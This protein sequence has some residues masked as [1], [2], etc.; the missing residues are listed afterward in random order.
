MTARGLYLSLLLLLLLPC[1]AFAQGGGPGEVK[2]IVVNSDT[3]EALPFAN[4][5]VEGTKFG[6]MTAEDG[7]FSFYVPAGTYTLITSYMGFDK[8]EHVDVVIEPESNKTVNFELKPSVALEMETFFVDG[9]GPVVDVKSSTVK[10]NKDSDDLNAFAVDNVQEAMALEAGITMKGGQLFVRGG[11]AGEVSMMIDGVPVND[12]L[13]GSVQVANVAVANSEAIIGG[14]DAEYGN[15]QSAVFNIVTREGGSQ[16]EGSLRYTTDDY[17]RQ[18]KTYTNFDR[19]AVGIGGPLFHDDFRWFLSAEGNFSDG[20]DL[21]LDRREEWTTLNGL[22]RWTDRARNTMQVTNKLT[23]KYSKNLKFNLEANLNWSTT[24]GYVHN[25]NQ[26]GYVNRLHMFERLE[27]SGEA[28]AEGGM[29]NFYVVRGTMPVKHGPWYTDYYMTNKRLQEQGLPNNFTK[30]LIKYKPSGSSQAVYEIA[31]AMLVN[32][33]YSGTEFYVLTDELFDGYMDTLSRWS[34]VR[35]DSS[36]IYYNSAEHTPTTDSYSNSVKFMAIHNIS[37]NVFYRLALTRLFF[38]NLRTVNGQEPWEYDTAGTPAT[39]HNG[40]TQRSISPSIYYTDPD[41]PFLASAYDY[42]TYNDRQS[43]SYILKFDMTSNRWHGHRIKTGFMAQYNDMRNNQIGSPG[44]TR[45]LVDDMTGRLLGTAQGLSANQFHNFSPLASFYA[46][47]QWDYQGMVVNFGLRYDLFSPGN[48]V[49]VLLR[50]NGVDP[51]IDRYKQAISPRLGLAFPITDR[52][53]FHFHY[54]RFIQAPANNFLFQSQ[55]PNSGQPVLGNPDLEPEIT[56]SYQAGV[57]HQFTE[58]VSMDCALFY[59]DIYSLI[60]TTTAQDTIS[61]TQYFRYINQAYA[62]ARGLEFTLRKAFSDN[63]GGQFAYTLS[64]ADGVA[65]DALFGATSAAGLTHLP[66]K[67]LPLGWDERHS[68][69]A[70]LRLADPGSWGGGVTYSFGS[71]FP[72]TPAF[73]NERR[74]D[75]TLENSERYPATHSL[76]LQA[77]KYFNVWG[78]DLT[79]FFDGRNLLDQDQISNH[80]PRIFP[81][82]RYADTSYTEY[83]TETGNYGGAYLADMDGDGEDEY[84]PVEDPRVYSARR[85]FR[86]GFGFEF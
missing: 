26:E 12:P 42:P 61:G 27:L 32:S 14:M 85:I 36:Q 20:E 33:A 47:D 38:D 19:F 35:N 7:T 63:Y 54:G 80:N 46:Q 58:H 40:A 6:A 31:D 39:L 86:I 55:D 23:W 65:S 37:D 28:S 9:E 82:L 24:D 71:G 1:L 11:R 8:G 66:T 78:Q 10:K 68:L 59:K 57:N 15:A 43:I 53:V 60:A 74:A 77:D 34:Y 21:T 75:P 70:T 69:S 49:E 48:G 18:D 56:I 44:L 62:S 79:V 67:E 84:H 29:R 3:G 5:V 2:G 45:M 73:R 4:V 22:L 64:W 25:W 50:S 72:Y 51:T 83:L 16:M 30:L 41:N 52:D 13:G 76:T 81:G 17:G